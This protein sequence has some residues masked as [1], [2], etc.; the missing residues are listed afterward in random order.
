M[1]E[2]HSWPITFPGNLRWTNATQIVKGMVPYGASNMAEIDNNQTDQQS[3]P[4]EAKRKEID[5]AKK[6][7]KQAIHGTNE[8]LITA[9]T[10]FPFTLFRDTVTVDREKVTITHRDFFRVSDVMST[11]IEDILNVTA[12]VGPVFGSLK[13]V[14]RIFS[15][16]KPYKIERLWRDDA[17]KL[18]RI[19][20]GYIIAKQKEIE[21]DALSTKELA[22]M[23]DQLGKDDHS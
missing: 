11:R 17:L 4:T 21:V 13:L 19:M 15:P 14:S 2:E 18:K 3:A 12:N 5:E 6:E 1:S 10:V 22:A 9:S 8:I 20:Q 23:L 7:L 16:D